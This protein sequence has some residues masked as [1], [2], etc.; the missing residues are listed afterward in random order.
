MTWYVVLLSKPAG[1]EG[2]VDL[3]AK[4]AELRV[5]CPD[6]AKQDKPVLQPS[7]DAT[8]MMGMAEKMMMGE[9][10]ET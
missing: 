7:G 5:Y 10:S 9:V 2:N 3:E 4:L 6:E 1:S 8:D